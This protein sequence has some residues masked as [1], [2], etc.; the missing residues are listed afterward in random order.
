MKA[1][2]RSCSTNYRTAVQET[3]FICVADAQVLNDDFVLLSAVGNRSLN[4]DVNL[5]FAGDWGR[6]S[7]ANVAVKKL[8]LSS[9]CDLCAQFNR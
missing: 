8:C 5:V 7:V 4:A 6:L 2:V 9:S 3:H 1:S